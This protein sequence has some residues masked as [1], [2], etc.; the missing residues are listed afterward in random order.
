MTSLATAENVIG[1]T[2]YTKLNGC[3]TVSGKLI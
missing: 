2:L 3:Y 1:N